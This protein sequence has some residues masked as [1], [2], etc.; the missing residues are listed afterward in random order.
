MD[1][2]ELTKQKQELAELKQ[3][4]EQESL[5]DD[6]R[7]NE[8]EIMSLLRKL[9]VAIYNQGNEGVTT[10][11]AMKIAKQNLRKT[12]TSNLLRANYDSDLKA[13][14]ERKAWAE[15]QPDYLKAET[16]LILAEGAY[17]AAELHYTAYENLYTAVK[18]ASQIVTNQNLN[19]VR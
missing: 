11:V 2:E 6:Q 9:P 19:Q 16:E 12:F 3:K 1:N 15:N 10:M 14:N 18:K 4:F 7:W 8:D 17:K 13:A 5:P